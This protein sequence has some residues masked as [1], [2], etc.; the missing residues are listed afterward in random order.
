MFR[1]SDTTHCSSCYKRWSRTVQTNVIYS[2]NFSV[3]TGQK[4]KKKIKEKKRKTKGI[5]Q[6]SNDGLQ[7]KCVTPQSLKLGKILYCQFQFPTDTGLGKLGIMGKKEKQSKS[8]AWWVSCM[9]WK[10]ML[11]KM[12]FFSPRNSLKDR[13]GWKNLVW[14][15]KMRWRNLV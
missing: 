13:N 11:H 1:W 5:Q 14:Q 12:S 15:T 3:F 2:F 8:L 10:S 7:N 6:I 4:K 9:S